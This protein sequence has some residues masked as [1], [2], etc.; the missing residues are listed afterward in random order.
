MAWP[1]IYPPAF[2]IVLVP[3]ASLPPVIPAIGF[4]V[5]T[6]M[7]LAG[8]YREMVRLSSRLGVATG[9]VAPVTLM[10]AASVSAIVVGLSP[11]L[12]C[13]RQGQVA[14]FLLWLCLWSLRR[15]LTGGERAAIIAGLVLSIAVAIK[16]TPILPAIA[17]VTVIG[18][19]GHGRR[20]ETGRAAAAG[21]AIG[22]VLLFAA[23]PLAM[24]GPART[25]ADL[26]DFAVRVIANRDLGRLVTPFWNNY[27]ALPLAEWIAGTAAGVIHTDWPGL[28]AGT[29][30]LVP[31]RA[32]AIT[33]AGVVAGVAIVALLVWACRRLVAVGDDLSVCVSLGLALAAMTLAQPLTWSHMLV[34]LAPAIVFTPAWLWR[35]GSAR[36]AW[37][38]ALWPAALVPMHYASKLA[39]LRALGW[40][41]PHLLAWYAGT[42]WVVARSCA[43]RPD[44]P[45]PRQDT[46]PTLP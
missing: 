2:A 34:L 15:L 22:L 7:A 33:A 14:L 44:G 37:W 27:S 4:F 32:A 13:L 45:T 42:A 8:V 41:A 3:V 5:A 10:R 29:A 40:R 18:T 12:E 20:R 25:A 43:R 21:L 11:V 28:W 30:P 46:V 6:L 1:Y 9:A 24:T 31:D 17:V 23:L 36:S 35:A 38:V 39:G 26:H 19:A 16:L